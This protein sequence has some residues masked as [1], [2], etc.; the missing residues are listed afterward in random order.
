MERNASRI[1]EPIRD[2]ELIVIFNQRQNW[3]SSVQRE[4]RLKAARLVT[5]D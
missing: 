1:A 5:Q 2:K 4:N 3:R